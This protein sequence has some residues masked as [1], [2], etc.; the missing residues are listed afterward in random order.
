MLSSP[1][2]LSEAHHALHNPLPIVIVAA[3]KK[4]SHRSGLAC[5]RKMDGSGFWVTTWF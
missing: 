3:I 1:H 2:S 5:P 4:Q